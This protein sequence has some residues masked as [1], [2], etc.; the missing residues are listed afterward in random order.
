DSE[1]GGILCLAPCFDYNLSLSAAVSLHFSEAK[2]DL[3]KYFTENDRLMEV[4]DP[5]MPGR[6]EIIS[7]VETAEKMTKI[8]FP[9]DNFKYSLFSDYVISAYDYCGKMISKEN[10]NT[11]SRH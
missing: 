3:M 1:N 9:N 6:E 2:A 8:A 7:A 11:Y 5:L 4:M 10:K